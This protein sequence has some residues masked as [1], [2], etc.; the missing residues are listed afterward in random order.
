MYV[1]GRSGLRSNPARRGTT[2]RRPTSKRLRHRLGALA[3]VTLLVAVVMGYGCAQRLDPME[4]REVAI[5]RDLAAYQARRLDPPAALTVEQAVAYALENNLDLW[6]DRQERRLQ[7]E[8]ATGAR[9]QMLPSLILNHDLSERNRQDASRSK[10]LAT[11]EIGT[12]SISEE[13]LTNKLDLSLTW[14]LIDFGVAYFRSRQARD[15]VALADE[16]MRRARQALAYRVRRAYFQAVATGEAARL[17]EDAAASIEKVRAVLAQEVASRDISALDGLRR[18]TPLLEQ[19]AAL[20]RFRKEHLAALEELSTLLGAPPGV[21]LDL[22][23]VD[24][25][26]DLPP[27]TLD[28]ARLEAEA[29]RQRPE[30]FQDDLEEAISRDDARVALIQMAPSPALF[31]RTDRDENRFLLHHEWQSIGLK[32]TLDLLSLPRKLSA[33]KEARLNEELTRRRRTATAVGILTQLHLAALGLREAEDNLALSREIAEKRLRLAEAVRES[34]QA[35]QGEVLELDLKALGA[36]ARYL[37]AWADRRAAEARIDG[38]VGRDPTHTAVDGWL[39]LRERACAATAE[40]VAWGASPEATRPPASQHFGTAAPWVLDPWWLTLGDPAGR[41]TLAREAWRVGWMETPWREPLLAEAARLRE[42]WALAKALREPDRQP[43]QRSARAPEW[44]ER[45]EKVRARRRAAEQ[46]T[47][48]IEPAKSAKDAEAKKATKIAKAARTASASAPVASRAAAAPESGS[49]TL[50]SAGFRA[51]KTRRGAVIHQSTPPPTRAT[52]PREE[53]GAASPREQGK[54]S[55]RFVEPARG[56]RI[57]SPR[58]R[59]SRY[60][61][62]MRRMS[63]RLR[64][65]RAQASPALRAAARSKAAGDSEPS[66][67]SRLSSPSGVPQPLA[68]ANASSAGHAPDRP[69]DLRGMVAPAASSAGAPPPSTAVRMASPSVPSTEADPRP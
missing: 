24:L 60:S 36:R 23:P 32:A 68:K 42:A 13:R 5:A 48:R 15:R 38:T 52:I 10:S 69:G 64:Q 56:E 7:D 62:E 11:R 17:A 6:V 50:A 1:F 37:V 66:R 28:L 2:S 41:R 47:E 12:A 63:E 55:L 25:D 22:A 61:E 39:Q 58:R 8:M 16:R 35:N 65:A 21:R 19:L 27:V 33:V 67:P 54:T 49:G 18:E 34:G 20:R 43:R 44:A 46:A 4:R 30:L 40:A 26:A 3:A 9:L 59:S 31:V 51:S 14:N 57:E 29:L 53:P 45:A